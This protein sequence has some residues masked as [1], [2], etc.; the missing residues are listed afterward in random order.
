MNHINAM[1]KDVQSMDDLSIVSFDAQGQSLRMMA[2]GVNFPLKVGSK[3]ILGAK[4]SNI[5]LA[6]SFSG[7][8]SISNQLHCIVER[9]DKGVLLCSVKLRFKG[10]ILE[11]ITTLASAQQME[12]HVGERVIALIKASELS[13]LEVEA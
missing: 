3:V 7:V 1:V 4:A 11:S 6:K 5:A 12:L 8:I 10:T 13:I 2:L 9:I